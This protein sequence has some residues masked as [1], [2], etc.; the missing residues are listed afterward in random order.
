MEELDAAR[1]I[2]LTTFKR[3]GT[4]V[5]CPVIAGGAGTY[6]V[7]TGDNAWMTRRLLRNPEV[8]A[9]VCDMRGRSNPS[10]STYRGRGEV[11]TSPGISATLSSSSR[12]PTRLSR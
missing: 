9:K 2:S 4:P 6:L 8:E 11:L 7:V 1:Y 3:D 10:A 12:V 5:A